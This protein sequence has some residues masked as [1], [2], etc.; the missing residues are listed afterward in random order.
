MKE[1][2]K[3]DRLKV[4]VKSEVVFEEGFTYS[5]TVDVSKG[6]LFISTPEPIGIGSPISLAIQIPGENPV[7]LSGVVKWVRNEEKDGER[8]GM[9]IEFNDMGDERI[10]SLKKLIK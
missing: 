10:D 3:H 1:K 9:G 6:G 4:T 7:E 5:N 2:R 8:A